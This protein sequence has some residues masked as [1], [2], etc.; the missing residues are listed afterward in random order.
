MIACVS[1]WTTLQRDNILKW[2]PKPL[3]FKERT[4]LRI[5]QE[6]FYFPLRTLIIKNCFPYIASSASL[7]YLGWKCDFLPSVQ[8]FTCLY[9]SNLGLLCSPLPQA[10]SKFLNLNSQHPFN[11][12]NYDCYDCYFS[13]CYLFLMV[14][15][16]YLYLLIW[17]TMFQNLKI[18][19]YK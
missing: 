14:I 9:L 17:F 12:L 15:L 13:I 7:V 2:F 18:K 1:F 5:H 4:N 3:M 11:P 6:D 8:W 10:I 16:E 19:C